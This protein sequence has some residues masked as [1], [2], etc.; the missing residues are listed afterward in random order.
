MSCI[1]SLNCCGNMSS[2]WHLHFAKVSQLRRAQ[3]TTPAGAR[4]RLLVP[5]VLPPPP[6]PLDVYRRRAIRRS[7]PWWGVGLV[8]WGLDSPA[9]TRS[10]MDGATCGIKVEVKSRPSE[11]PHRVSLR[12]P[13]PLRQ[14]GTRV[15]MGI[16]EHLADL[17]ND[18]ACWLCYACKHSTHRLSIVS[19]V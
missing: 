5:A 4:E 16:C 14:R 15:G 1:F 7:H 13:P 8:R 11:P 9:D 3:P 6:S 19:A 17:H 10:G 12:S 2:C 18:V